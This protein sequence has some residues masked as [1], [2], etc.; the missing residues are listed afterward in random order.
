MRTGAADRHRCAERSLRRPDNWSRDGLSSGRWW[1]RCVGAT[2]ESA[3]V[4]VDVQVVRE[5]GGSGGLAGVEADRDV[6]VLPSVGVVDTDRDRP[7]CRGVGVC[8]HLMVQAEVAELIAPGA[9]QDFDRQPA[10]LGV[11]RGADGSPAGPRWKPS[12]P[13]GADPCNCPR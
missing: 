4:V 10:V 12:P 11:G 6:V 2:E 8:Q 7:G 13:V 5:R 3:D 1:L 9:V